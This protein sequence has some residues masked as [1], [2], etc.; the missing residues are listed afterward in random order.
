MSLILESPLRSTSNLCSHDLYKNPFLNRSPWSAAWGGKESSGLSLPS[1][2]QGPH[3]I[4]TRWRCDDLEW[5]S[6][7]CILHGQMPAMTA[8][9]PVA[10]LLKCIVCHVPIFCKLDT[11]TQHLCYMPMVDTLCSLDDSIKCLNHPALASSLL[12]TLPPPWEEL[13]LG[14]AFKFR[15]TNP[16][17]ADSTT[18]FIR[19]PHSS[20]PSTCPNHQ[21]PD[22]WGQPPWPRGHQRASSSQS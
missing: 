6:S 14:F 10:V 4:L 11:L 13:F 7:A 2:P 12:L 21:P 17:S 8:L 9:V 15:P 5:S 3:L 16:K 20:L 1:S 22:H 19:L 18:S